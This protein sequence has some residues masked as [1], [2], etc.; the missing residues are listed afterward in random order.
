MLSGFALSV[1]FIPA[2]LIVMLGTAGKKPQAPSR[3][4]ESRL[5]AH[6]GSMGTVITTIEVGDP[7][8]RTFQRVEVEVDTGSTYTALPREMLQAL[9]VPVDTSVQARLAD[10][11]IQEVEIGQATIR[12]G[13]KQ[14]STTVIFAEEGEPT[15][16]GAIALEETLLAVDPGNNELIPVIEK[17]Y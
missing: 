3:N 11:T 7:Q 12:L 1:A 14:F 15:L 4:K 6:T 5:G 10:G 2:F 9:G 13:R 17:R 16:L 8:E